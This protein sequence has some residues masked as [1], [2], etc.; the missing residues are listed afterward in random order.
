VSAWPPARGRVVVTRGMGR[1]VC[2]GAQ[3]D[4]VVKRIHALDAKIGAMR[5]IISCV[6]VDDTDEHAIAGTTTGE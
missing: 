4:A 3:F 1:S 2:I 5:R 6:D